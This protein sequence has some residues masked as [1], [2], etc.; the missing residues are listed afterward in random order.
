[1][2]T[3]IT[4]LIIFFALSLLLYTLCSS[5]RENLTNGYSSKNTLVLISTQCSNYLNWQTTA[6]YYSFKKLMPDISI[7]ALQSCTNSHKFNHHKISPYFVV[8]DYTHISNEPYAAF[9]RPYGI[10]EWLDHEYDNLKD[11]EVIVVIDP[12]MV[13]RKPIDDLIAKVKPGTAVV[14]D[15]Y[16]F[17]T[18]DKINKHKKLLN[19]ST[20]V[21]TDGYGCLLYTSP[22]PRD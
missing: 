11:I 4:I 21:K 19:K 1:M 12:D 20:S 8:K 9:N 5:K 6:A 14:A 3:L 17:L 16:T 2:R 10:S 15:N 13:L 7:L 22:S 18:E